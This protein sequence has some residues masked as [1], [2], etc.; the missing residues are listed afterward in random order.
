SRARWDAPGGWLT[1]PSPSPEPE[2]DPREAWAILRRNWWVVAGCTL[3]GLLVAL[4]HV[5][6]ATPI[7]RSSTTLQFQ[8]KGSTVPVLDALRDLQGG[9][10][11]GTEMEVLRSRSLAEAV[12]DSL[13]LQVLV[14]GPREVRRTAVLGEVQADADA[15]EGRVRLEQG[16]DGRFTAEPLHGPAAERLSAAAPGEPLRLPGAT[17]VLAPGAG[18]VDRV[19]L[20]I[21]PRT[22]AAERFGEALGVSRP[23]RDANVVEVRFDSP[24]PELA[25]DVANVLAHQYLVRR[26]AVRKVSDRSTVEFLR[27]QV[28]TLQV[29]LRTAEEAVRRFREQNRVVSL[30]AEAEAQVLRLA[31]LQAQRA[32]LEAEREALAGLLA[33]AGSAGQGGSPYRRLLAFPTLLRNQTTATLLEA[34]TAREAELAQLRV[35]RTPADLDLQALAGQVRDLEEQAAAVVATYL[36]GL[37]N[38]VKA[39]DREL[40]GFGQR[41][42][43]VPAKEVEYARLERSARVL[44]DIYTLLQTRLKEAEV[45]EAVEDASVRVVD[46]AVVGREPVHPRPLLTMALSLLLG[47]MVGSGLA[48]GRER[49]DDVIRTREDV[50][51]VVSLPVLGFI[52]DAGS[53]RGWLGRMRTALPGADRHLP[54]ARVLAP[55]RSSRGPFAEAYR[56]LRTN[57]TFARPEDDLRLVVITS[58]APADGKT[59]TV[60]NLAATLAQ[61]G[62]RVLV[63]DADLRRGAIHRI[64]GTARTPGLSEILAGISGPGESLQ[65]VTLEGGVGFDFVATGLL[66]PNPTELLESDRMTTFLQHVKSKYDVALIDTPPVT[67][68]T[69]AA[70]VG[71]GADGVI[72]VARSGTT[73]A[74]VLRRAGSELGQLRVDVLGVI[75]N[76]VGRGHWGPEY[77]EAYYDRDGTA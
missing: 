23:N 61:R 17:V 41:L 19:D 18:D 56:T 7:Y 43:A 60:V 77:G 66:P 31:A 4:V 70:V 59:T 52:P 51:A 9:T 45:V 55:L 26:N 74:R 46:V 50:Q 25:R 20:E 38:Q 73:R 10:E 21:L 64:L 53:G 69:D 29:Q 6:V 67:I 15:P 71:A 75:L 35:R 63:V 49:S 65:R 33:D 34:L 27:N 8:E 68:L 1:P 44:A 16:E 14:G 22:A 58:T 54:D 72:L 39:I 28:D 32:E 48:I 40:A 47:A 11:V 5:K 37:E 3:L 2:F 30:E 42:A 24:D 57:L 36:G 62:S 13:G 12:I 76:A